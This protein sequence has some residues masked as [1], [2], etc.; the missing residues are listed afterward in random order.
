[1]T[2]TGTLSNQ[3]TT[4]VT[5]TAPAATSSPV[6]VTVTATSRLEETRT[7]TAPITIP[8]VPAVTSTNTGMAGAVGSVYSAQ[9]A[10][11]GGISPYTWTVTSGNLPPGLSLSS[12][13][14]IT[15]TPLAGASG[16][17]NVTFQL[18][19]AGSPMALTASKTLAV[20]IT[21]APAIAFTG[22]MPATGS[23]NETYAGSA[24]AAGGLGTLTYSVAGGA[25][26]TGV[27]LNTDTGAVA[28]TTTVAGT[29]NFTI[30]ASDVFGDAASHAY[31]I[32]VVAPSLTVT[33]NA[34]ALPY[35]VTGQSYSQTLTVSG[36]TGTGYTW[37]VSGLSNGLTYAANGA[38]LTINGPATTAG[39]VNFTA[40]ATDNVGDTSSPLSYSIPVYGPLALPLTIPST[41]PS[42]AAVGVLYGGTVVAT[43]GSG[44]Y[45]WT[46]T[47][48]SDGLT[49]STRGGTLSVGGTPAATGT[50][51]LNV[52]VKDPTTNTT[53]GLTPTLTTVY[54]A[55]Y[56]AQRLTSSLGIS[57][58]NNHSEPARV[59]AVAETTHGP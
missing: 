36:G 38:T 40:T 9:L 41:L 20:A 47:G 13:G 14:L 43:G 27:A 56:A 29:Y 28:G 39:T 49:I 31:Q 2:G 11:S 5:Y 30:Q 50:V 3:T 1:M 19:D 7:A 6:T 55:V 23:Y 48:Q 26:P 58:V 15:G 12:S 35:A 45:T 10:G 8:V 37:V 54:S 42:G 4:S 57:V 16:N 52:S 59:P 53:V 32:V 24:A 34:G 33:P 25:L 46:V 17:T 22:V 21:P 51:S 44:N 18:K